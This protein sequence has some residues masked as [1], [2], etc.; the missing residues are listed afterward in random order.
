MQSFISVHIQTLFIR[1]QTRGCSF[2]TDENVLFCLHIL[3]SVL[4]S[5]LSLKNKNKLV[6]IIRQCCKITGVSL[7]DL[8]HL[9]EMKTVSKVKTFV[10]D[11]QHSLHLEFQKLPSG[12][13]FIHPR[14]ARIDTDCLLSPLLLAF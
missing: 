6:K 2:H 1:R 5:S 7:Y 11:P 13:R 14:A 12:R 9:Y 3:L 8:Q 10:L 4:S